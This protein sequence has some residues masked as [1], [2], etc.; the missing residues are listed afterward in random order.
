MINNVIAISG[1]IAVGK[2]TLAT[3]LA[4]AL[5]FEVKHESVTDNP[6]LDDFYLDMPRWA[7]HLQFHFLGHRT[8][9][10]QLA[11][12]S[13]TPT[14]LDRTIYED[15][16]VFAPALAEMGYLSQRDFVTYRR[17]FEAIRSQLTPPKITIYLSASV[18]TLLHRIRTRGRP[19]ELDIPKAYLTQLQAKYDSW[20]RE[21][22]NSTLHKVDTDLIDIRDAAQIQKIA[23]DLVIRLMSSHVCS[24]SENS[25]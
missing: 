22:G 6:Y 5:D 10:H 8:L 18:D 4:I 23:D 13:K 17:L 3:A 11:T 15:G 2:T 9:Q 21:I 12:L 7:T 19:F 25:V 20:A 14:I 16:E 24:S 1:N